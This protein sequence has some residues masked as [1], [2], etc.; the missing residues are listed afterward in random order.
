MRNL[1]I[2]WNALCCYREDCISGSD[3]DQEWDDICNTMAMIEESLNP[4]EWTGLTL[5]D[6]P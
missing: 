3:Y 4:E 1:E 2:I 5:M 6:R